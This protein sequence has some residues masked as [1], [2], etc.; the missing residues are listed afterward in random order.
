MLLPALLRVRITPRSRE[1]LS[2][3]EIYTG[4]LIRY[5]LLQTTFCEYLGQEH[6]C[7]Y[8]IS[9]RRV[10]SSI[11]KY[12]HCRNLIDLDLPVHDIQVGN[13]V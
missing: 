5:S 8:V 4:D 13:W 9:P 1:K 11:N 12:F 2:P 6:L 3:F 7:N 10:L